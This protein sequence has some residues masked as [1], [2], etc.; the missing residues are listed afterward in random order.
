[1]Y[2][3][4]CGKDIGE[5]KFCP[6]CGASMNPENNQYQPIN[7]VVKENDQSHFGF[8]LLSFFIPVAGI[9][10]YCIWKDEFPLKAKSCLKGFVS[11]IVLYV[12]FICCIISTAGFLFTDNVY[13]NDDFNIYYNTHVNAIVEV[14]PY[15]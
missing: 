7:Q 5:S 8:A 1:M 10:L 3:H 14:V 9:V 13:D 15:D 4:Q 11:A 2:C 6:Y 12:V